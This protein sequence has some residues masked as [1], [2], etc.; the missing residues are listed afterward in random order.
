[1]SERGAILIC[2]A[3]SALRETLAASLRAAG[4]PVGLAATPSQATRLAR[5]L[6][7]CCLVLDL[8]LPGSSAAEVLSALRMDP[9]LAALPAI[10]LTPAGVPPHD[11]AVPSGVRTLSKPVDPTAL[12]QAVEDMLSPTPPATRAPGLALDLRALAVR[13]GE[14]AV[15]LTPTELR[16]LMALLERQGTPV[17]VFELL[18]AVWGTPPALGGPELVRVHIRNLRTKL[19][20]LTGAPPEIIHTVARQGYMVPQDVPVVWPSPEEPHRPK[21]SGH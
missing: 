20:E 16:L 2:T 10:V 13:W 21:G 4:Y 6:R 14:Q 18:V 17:S 5:D 15:T 12:A 19:A 1:M 9:A 7:L 11:P 8:V 3:N